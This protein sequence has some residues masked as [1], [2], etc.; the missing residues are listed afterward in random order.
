M[1]DRHNCHVWPE[2]EQ[3]NLYD[4]MKA[5]GCIQWPCSA[6]FEDGPTHLEIAKHGMAA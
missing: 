4:I 6:S 3:K 2:H 1:F 5:L